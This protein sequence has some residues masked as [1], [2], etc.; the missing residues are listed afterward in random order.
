MKVP[1]ALSK[2]CSAA[3]LIVGLPL[4]YTG[5]GLL[6]ILFFTHSTS[7]ALMTVALLLEITGATAHY[8][9]IKH[10]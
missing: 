2:I 3:A 7:N 9:K 6:V 10:K 5:V 1:K 4:L 8:W